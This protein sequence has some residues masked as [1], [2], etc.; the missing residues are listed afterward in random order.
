MVDSTNEK[1]IYAAAGITGVVA[2]LGAAYYIYSRKSNTANEEETATT[3]PE[4]ETRNVFLM[5]ADDKNLLKTVKRNEDQQF[6]LTLIKKEAVSHDTFKLTFAFP[7]KD[8]QLGCSGGAHVRLCGNDKDGKPITRMYSMI[9][10]L[11]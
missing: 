10:H 5:P 9:S 4:F 3:A 2:A 7:E 11:D 6:P 8:M 1:V